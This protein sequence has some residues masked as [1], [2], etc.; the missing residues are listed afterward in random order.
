MQ[1]D[2]FTSISFLTLY[3]V[4]FVFVTFQFQ[5]LTSVLFREQE[6]STISSMD[7]CTDEM[8]CHNQRSQLFDQLVTFFPDSMTQPTG[9]LVDLIPL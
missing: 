2:L 6:E 4:Q 7:G 5:L 3:S 8:D 1:T 9:N